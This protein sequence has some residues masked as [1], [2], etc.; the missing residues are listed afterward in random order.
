MRWIG[1]G[2][3]VFMLACK[4]GGD[5]ECRAGEMRCGGTCVDTSSNPDHCG[6]CNE[7]CT[8]EEV[9]AAGACM[10][11]CPG[12]QMECDRACVSTDS[13]PRHCGGCGI[14]CGASET[15]TGGMCMGDEGCG[16]AEQMCGAECVSTDT[17]ED[18]CGRCDNACGDDQ[19]CV[20]GTCRD[21]S[22]PPPVTCDPPI[23]PEDTSS[24]DTVV[25]TGT[26]ESC[27]YDALAAAVASGGVITFDC[28]GAATIDV[29]AALQL[30][31][32][33]DTI[34]DGAGDITLDGGSESD[35]QTR[36]FEF[37]SPDY[38]VTETRVVLQGLTMQNAEAPATDFTPQDAG[39]PQCA[40]GY[41]DGEGGAI[42]IRDGVLHIIDC[43]FR[44]NRAA[45]TGP[46]TGGGAIY[47]LGALEVVVV[48]SSFIG[49][50]GSN[51]G[52]VGLLQTDG[53]FYNTLFEGNRAT[54]MG[55]NFG[56]A[57]GCPPFNH[58]EQGGAG[59]NSGAVGIDGDSVEDI[60][61]CGVTFRNNQANELGTVSRTPN[62]HRGI[63]TFNRCLF[64]G[65]FA[66]DGGGAIWMQDMQFEMYSS[67]VVGNSSDGL[68]GGVR[69]DQGPHGS[70]IVIENTTFQGNVANGA[71]GG[72]LV[73]SGEGLVRNCT[74][75][76]NEA[77]GGEG[78]FGAAIVSHGAE[79][80]GLQVRN[81]IFWNNIDDHQWTPMTCSVGNPGTPVPL[82]GDAN[83]Q[84]P[85]I[86]NGD[87][88]VE[89]NLCTV[90]T[91]FADAMLEALGDNGGPT[92]TMAVPSGSP[93]IGIGT[94]CP[95]TDQRG[96]PRDTANCAA[97][98]LQP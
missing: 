29:T 23:A 34:I 67:A 14:E 10:A 78:F 7:A 52:A 4:G 83:I 1:A 61:F 44:N 41:K 60:D 80:Q 11:G 76:E 40:W 57:S 16:A 21:P 93:A 97:G 91:S 68:G 95:S 39:N 24:P 94:D 87:A 48:G 85:M 58:A 79:S 50:E 12:A 19:T 9:C 81:T 5:D 69:I 77:A 36:I 33:V 25:G 27:T 92:P 15:C 74:F 47:A 46:D 35:R 37:H 8:G 49:N 62:A 51:G 71:L 13:D 75:A 3:L 64:D 84:W 26:P 56:G 55:Q 17:D 82:P 28:G 70:T 73:F 88:M 18:H 38:R 96:E 22:P 66:G 42:R 45:P 2:L 72:A 65:N 31:T 59:G 86:R 54:G 90:G 89:D 53:V 20:G 98:A 32:D 43:V 30:R 63:S 6:A